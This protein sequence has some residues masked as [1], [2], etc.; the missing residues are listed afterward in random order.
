MLY[1]AW[2]MLFLKI[3]IRILKNI[4]QNFREKKIFNPPFHEVLGYLEFFG[5]TFEGSQNIYEIV[6]LHFLPLL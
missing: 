6:K 1:D 4:S 3:G 2:S 5:S